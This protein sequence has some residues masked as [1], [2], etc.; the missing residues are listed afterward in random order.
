M[1]L[2]DTTRVTYGLTGFIPL[3]EN[4]VLDLSI[5]DLTPG[6]REFTLVDI[7]ERATTTVSL[8]RLNRNEAGEIIME[9]WQTTYE[10]SEK[11]HTL[12]VET[13]GA[14]NFDREKLAIEVKLEGFLYNAQNPLDSISI[15]ARFGV[16]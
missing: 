13:T 10:L 5:R 1:E 11:E 2:F 12:L 15:N 3:D 7:W 14:D 8:H 16:R 4:L 6:L 9:N